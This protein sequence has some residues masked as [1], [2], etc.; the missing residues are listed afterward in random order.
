MSDPNYVIK[1]G[2]ITIRCGIL[3]QKNKRYCKLVKNNESLI[4]NCYD[5]KGNTGT[6]KLRNKFKLSRV[7]GFDKVIKEFSKDFYIDVY[8]KKQKFSLLFSNQTETDSWYNCLQNNAQVAVGNE[9]LSSVVDDDDESETGIKDNVLYDSGPETTAKFDVKLKQNEDTE[10]LGLTS[11]YRLYVSEVCLMLEDVV[12]KEAKYRWYYDALRRYGKQDN[13]FVIQAGRRSETGAGTF[14]FMY[15]DSSAITKS[16]DRLTKRRASEQLT[17]KLNFSQSETKIPSSNRMSEPI[18]RTE[19]SPPPT[20]QIESVEDKTDITASTRFQYPHLAS[21]AEFKRELQNKVSG[22]PKSIGDLSS[23]SNMEIQKSKEQKNIEKEKGLEAISKSKDKKLNDKAKLEVTIEENDEDSEN[24]YDELELPLDS[25]KVA[26]PL[27]EK[28][29]KGDNPTKKRASLSDKKHVPSEPSDAHVSPEE[30]EEPSVYE[31]AQTSR[32][33]AWKN[34]GTED[35]EHVE[36]YEL[37]KAGASQNALSKPFE[38]V[39]NNEEEIDDT[40]DHAFQTQESLKKE[41]IANDSKN[42]YGTSSGKDISEVVTEVEICD[43]DYECIENYEGLYSKQKCI[44]QSEAN[45]DTD[46][47]LYSKQKCITQS[48][49]NKD[50]DIK[51]ES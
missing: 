26:K 5:S 41:N 32:Q 27:S 4:L 23:K 39:T 10:R 13:D 35:E 31:D 11:T 49:A 42:V 7:K 21:S 25:N 16:I 9:E 3:K 48:E 14:T 24:L 45:E 19:K 36:N 50:T 40:Y 22:K 28:A 44:P 18:P 43:P 6:L 30:P 51:L 15:E 20:K 1:E 37:I 2:E 47:G 8:L 38:G 33:E 12:T 34:Q 29:V 46:E 17:N